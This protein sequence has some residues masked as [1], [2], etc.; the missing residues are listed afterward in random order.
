MHLREVIFSDAQPI[1][2]YGPGF[3]RIAGDVMEGAVVV[4][5]TGAF[6]W[7]GYED[8]QPLLALAGEIDVLFVG[9]GT[10]TAHLPSEFRT[11]LE[12]A[13]LGVEAMATPAAL[14]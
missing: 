10:D 11:A 9:T 3:F 12:H 8:T 5:E 4:T 7:A 6:G 14:T 1:D 2:S 13:G